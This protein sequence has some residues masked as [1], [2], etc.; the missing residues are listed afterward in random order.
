MR[1]NAELLLAGLMLCLRSVNNFWIVG[2]DGYGIVESEHAVS[3][4][5][6]FDNFNTK[7]VVLSRIKGSAKPPACVI[8]NAVIA[9][10]SIANS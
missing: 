1:S 6:H 4:D 8:P 2:Y 7:R 3:I 9:Q 10:I 5:S